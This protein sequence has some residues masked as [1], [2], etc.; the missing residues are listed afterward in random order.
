MDNT[1][2]K[3]KVT[4]SRDQ[5]FLET[6]TG[7]RCSPLESKSTQA[8]QSVEV[9]MQ[10][11]T[12][13]NGAGT[14]TAGEGAEQALS[15]GRKATEATVGTVGGMEDSAHNVFAPVGNTTAVKVVPSSTQQNQAR[16]GVSTAYTEASNRAA[17]TRV[18]DIGLLSEDELLSKLRGYIN[19][20]CTFAKSTRNVHKELKKTLANS[21]KIMAQYVKV[22]R[23]GRNSA[24]ISKA[25][26]TTEAL[27][28]E[29]ARDVSKTNSL[30]MD[31]NQEV[32]AMRKEL[33]DIRASQC[34]KKHD[35]EDGGASS[36]A[37]VTR[38]K[39]LVKN[40]ERDLTSIGTETVTRPKTKGKA[41]ARPKRKRPPAIIVRIKDGTFS[42]ALKKL[43]GNGQVK[44]FSDDIVGLTKT[45]N[46][47][48]LVRTNPNSESGPELIL[49]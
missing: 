19:T 18:I 14:V 35:N 43:K 28:N 24:S 1:T 34:H 29:S 6:A 7:G 45:R 13:S 20:M 22:L 10:A 9:L 26:V 16:D 42:E 48:L 4:A 46:G 21:N 31:I 33:N 27:S 23:Q 25:N 39:P 37:E 3:T 15:G 41:S 8:T 30:I 36:W 5:E 2:N 47:D 12:A 17:Q 44:T 49:I 11:S 38:I 32:K 40:V